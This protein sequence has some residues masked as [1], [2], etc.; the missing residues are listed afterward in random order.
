MATRDHKCRTR[1]P[2]TVRKV[3]Q[4][5]SQ[6]QTRYAGFKPTM[7]HQI[8]C[9]AN[10]A[11]QAAEI[12]AGAELIESARAHVLWTFLF[13]DAELAQLFNVSVHTIPDWKKIKWTETIRSLSGRQIGETFDE[14]RA[15]A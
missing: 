6:L 8:A 12:A 5:C 4:I 1:R 3:S 11:R 15:I 10:R 13:T 14:V 9:W 7:P 2:T